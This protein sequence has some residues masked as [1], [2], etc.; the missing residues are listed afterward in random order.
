MSNDDLVIDLSG[1]A[2]SSTRVGGLGIEWRPQTTVKGLSLFAF[3]GVGNN[4]I[5]YAM[6]GVRIY[7]GGEDK[8]LQARHR[9]DDP[10][11]LLI[12]AAAS[13]NEAIR[14][15]AE[16]RAANNNSNGG[17]GTTGGALLVI[18]MLFICCHCL[19]S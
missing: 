14:K 2:F 6:A 7:F 5:D 4:N 9:E 11:N 12:N 13:L 8:T 1:H 15:E 17:V 16:K 10:V 19:N 18:G 3:G